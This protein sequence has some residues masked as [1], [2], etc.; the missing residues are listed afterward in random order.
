[1]KD[2][3]LKYGDKLLYMEGIVVEVD[4]ASIAVDLKGR[5]GY[6]KAPRRMF[7]CDRQPVVGQEFGWTMSFPEQIS[8]TPN[9]KYV[10]NIAK[11]NKKITTDN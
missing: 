9:D 3:K 6:F 4:D 1:M 11:R 8:E 5:L 10:S 2:S 7:I